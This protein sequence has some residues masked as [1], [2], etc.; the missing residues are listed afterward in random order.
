MKGFTFEIKNNL[1]EKKH[2][3]AM[4]IAV[5][6]FMWLDDKITKVDEN[7]VGWVLGGKPIIFKEVEAE[8]GISQRTYTRWI[9][10]LE[11]YPYIKAI[12]TPT[13]TSF[14]VFKAHKTFG[15]KVEN[16]LARAEK[17]VVKVLKEIVKEKS[18]TPHVASGVA[19]SGESDTP[20]VA[21][22]NKD[23][24]VDSTVDT[25][26]RG[27][28]ILKQENRMIDETLVDFEGFQRLV[29]AFKPLN[30]MWQQVYSQPHEEEALLQI[31][32]EIGYDKTLATIKALPEYIEK[33]YCPIITRPME[34]K[35]NL[36]KLIAFA[37]QEKK[38]EAKGRKYE[39]GKI[40]VTKKQ[41]AKI[42]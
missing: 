38:I 31:V 24:T 9:A 40:I 8:L 12:R 2:I 33:A 6:L 13:G 16:K 7:G 11:K 5:W 29:Q 26:K 39:A 34:L 18:D 27:I 21:H 19:T 23:S 17:H 30:P 10:Q 41:H 4:G 28:A 22:P 20:L 36:G 14:R 35:W 15:R 42:R 1:L 25:L 37:K 3:E 32:K